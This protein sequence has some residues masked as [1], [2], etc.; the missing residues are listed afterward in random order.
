[1]GIYPKRRRDYAEKACPVYRHTNKTSKCPTPLCILSHTT[2]PTR[3]I[4]PNYP[5][6]LCGLI[7]IISLSH[8]MINHKMAPK[9]ISIVPP[10]IRRLR[11]STLPT[12]KISL[13]SIPFPLTLIRSPQP[14]PPHQFQRTF[15]NTRRHL[16]LN[17]PSLKRISVRWFRSR[18]YSGIQ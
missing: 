16:R 14:P 8:I 15:L 1:M 7:K 6:G 5:M 3:L 11:T 10:H 13:N 2:I 9:I 12:I 4:P 18:T 17:H